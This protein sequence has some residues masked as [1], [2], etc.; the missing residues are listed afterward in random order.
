MQKKKGGQIT[1]L[2]ATGVDRW[3]PKSRRKMYTMSSNLGFDAELRGSLL[4]LTRGI[5]TWN[6]LKRGGGCISARPV[7][8]TTGHAESHSGQSISWW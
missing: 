6:T 3:L 4:H 7:F 1:E 5:S 2:L 8:C